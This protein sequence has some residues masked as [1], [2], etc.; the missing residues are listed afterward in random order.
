MR[1]CFTF[2]IAFA[3]AIVVLIPGLLAAD[4]SGISLEVSGVVGL[5]P[6]ESQ[7]CVTVW[8]PIPDGMA[9]SS[10]QWYNN[11]AG[12]V[13]PQ[14]ALKSGTP[15][16][17]V[18]LDDSRVIAENVQGTSSGWSQL[19][20]DQPVACLSEGLYLLFRFPEG[21]EYLTD[22]SGGGAALGYCIDGSGCPGWI[23][24]DGQ[25]WVAFSGDFGF[26]V[27]PQFVP[28]SDAGLTMKAINGGFEKEA[29]VPKKTMLL[30]PAPNP[31]NPRT[32]LKFDLAQSGRVEI[33]IY[34]VRG[35]LVK[36]LVDDEYNTGTHESIWEGCDDGGRRVSSG[37]YFAQM[38]TK[39]VVMSQR[40][41]LVQ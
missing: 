6:V 27:K 22:G 10:F 32:S 35:E 7:S 17:P 14:I 40:L 5:R 33:T 4:D 1:Y 29:R 37:V 8:V 15:N 20:L 18:S 34:N 23:S 39:Q 36:R 19:D 38:R 16:S 21:N 41:V 12:T 11:D 28:A 30:L 3:L 13:Y 25:D 31:F 24:A 9:M 26:A 2:S